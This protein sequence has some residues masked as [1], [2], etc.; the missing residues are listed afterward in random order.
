MERTS[1]FRNLSEYQWKMLSEIFRII[2]KEIV[3][4]EDKEKLAPGEL[5]ISYTDGTLYIRNPHT[6]DLFSPNSIEYLRPIMTKF[7]PATADLNADS[8][9]Y[10]KVY[11]SISQLQQLGVRLSADSIIRQMKVPSVLFSPIQYDNYDRL[12]IPSSNGI[13]VVF[14]MSEEY[15]DAMYFDLVKNKTYSG[16]YNFETH[17]LEGWVCQSVHDDIMVT[18]SG[19]AA[20][21]AS[22]GTPLKDLQVLC[23]RVQ[24]YVEPLCLLSVDGTTAIPIQNE[25]GDRLSHGLNQNSII[26]LIYDDIKKVW[27]Y[28]DSEISPQLVINRIISQRIKVAP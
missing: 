28:C 16:F 1:D 11:R 17:M 14:K 21:Q 23:L 12:G 7:N 8:V 2:I 6:G 5:G 25:Y 4:D 22:Y 18:T 15:A 27:V 9:G 24:H 10:I 13:I 20:A 26:M 19:G 3:T